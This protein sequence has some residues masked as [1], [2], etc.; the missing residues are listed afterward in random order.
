MNK[1][2][3]FV[4]TLMVVFLIPM[5]CND[6]FLNTKPLDKVSSAV[7]WTDGALAQA[8][9]FGTYSFLGYCGFEVNHRYG[10]G[11]RSKCSG[12]QVGAGDGKLPAR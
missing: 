9:V 10:F 4:L 6:D 1:A 5:S 8:F 3:I 11:Q 7:T 2:K 12:R